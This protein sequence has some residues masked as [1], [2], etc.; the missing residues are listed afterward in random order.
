MEKIILITGGTSGLG[1]ATVKKLEN[2]KIIL[3]YNNN[4]L[5]AESMK[6]ENIDVFK[7]DMTSENDIKN[8]YNYVVEKYGYIDV[9]INN[10]AIAIDTL[11]EDKTKENFI[12]TLD[13]NLIGPFL[14]SRYFGDLMYQRKSGKIINISSTNG[15]DTNYPMSLDYDASK[16]GL[17]SLT[18]NLAL[19]YAPYVLVN[20]IAP[21]WINTEMNKNLDNDFIDNETKKILLN[22]FAE[23]EEIANVIKFLVSDDA[24]YINNTVIRID[25]GSY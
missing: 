13:T 5:K 18:R 10:A 9:L 1:Y 25:G 2:C 7:C 15:I 4:A 17:I 14:L 21:G 12:K 3:T 16:A 19:Q 20:A 23:P 22:R 11:Y 24:S 8:L 6:S